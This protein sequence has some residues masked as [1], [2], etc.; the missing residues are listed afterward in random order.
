MT[1][2]ND[3]WSLILHGGV[4]LI[5]GDPDDAHRR[6]CRLALEAGVAILASGGTALDAAEATI[7]CLED[8]PTFNA[9]FGSVLN[10][11]GDVQ[12]DAAIM[13]GDTLQVGAVA[14]IEGV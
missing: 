1:V 13:E 9:G 2:A 14:A 10:S 7:C 11:D 6:G 12:M 4:K 5:A 3:G 8:D